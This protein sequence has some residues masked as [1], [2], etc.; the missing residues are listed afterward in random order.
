MCAIMSTTTLCHSGKIPFV[1]TFD[2]DFWTSHAHFTEASDER[3]SVD[4]LEH[5]IFIY[6]VIKY[7][8][9]IWD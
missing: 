7:R 9:P 6:S 2:S 4:E 1:K 8:C 3:W 5:T